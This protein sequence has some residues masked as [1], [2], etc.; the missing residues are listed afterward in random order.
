MRA[1]KVFSFEEPIDY[2]KCLTLQ[3][4]L[5]NEVLS[6]PAVGYLLLLEHTP[7]F[8]LGRRAKQDN[9]LVPYKLLEKEGIKVV[10]TDRGGDITYHGPGQLISYPIISL[11]CKVKEYVWRLEEAIIRLLNTYGIKSGRKKGYP[12]VWIDERR[13][14]ASIGIGIKRKGKI[15]ISYHGTAFNVCPNL[16]HFSFITPCGISGIEMVSIESLTGESPPMTEIKKLYVEEFKRLFSN[17]NVI[18]SSPDKLPYPR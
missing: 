13:K 16:R 6:D 12:G 1:I 10:E 15:W 3:K 4:N 5:V 8:T 9:I 17:Y 18:P 14:I 7:V 2:E 11:D